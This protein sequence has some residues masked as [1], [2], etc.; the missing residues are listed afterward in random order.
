MIVDSQF[1]NFTQLI[2]QGIKSIAQT[3]AA[4]AL[5]TGLLAA[6]A[7]LFAGGGPEAPAPAEPEAGRVLARVNQVE[8]TYGDFK[9]RLEN[10]QQERGPIARER[11]L[12]YV[13][14]KQ[15]LD[16][17]RYGNERGI[18]VAGGMYIVPAIRE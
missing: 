14:Y 3:S 2:R 16:L 8:I 10:L 13:F 6:P 18:Q 15:Y 9:R 12:Q 17:K 11:F 4:L 7:V 1:C 5:A